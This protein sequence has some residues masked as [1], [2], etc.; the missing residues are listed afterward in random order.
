MK[1][2]LN[3]SRAKSKKK[4]LSAKE[5]EVPFSVQSN[6]QSSTGNSLDDSSS[7]PSSPSASSSVMDDVVMSPVLSLPTLLAQAS[8]KPASGRKKKTVALTNGAGGGE[9]T[10][11]STL[12]GSL[13]Q[14]AKAAM[15]SLVPLFDKLPQDV[16]FGD[17][18]L[19][20]VKAAAFTAF[21]GKDEQMIDCLFDD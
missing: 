14:K 18:V 5:Q 3:L 10:K 17:D 9:T 7:L 2:D 1:V 13:L 15:S 11:R 16:A 20:S 21:C 6:N 12:H 4:S 8:E 19:A